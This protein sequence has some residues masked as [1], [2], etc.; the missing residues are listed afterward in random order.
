MVFM[1]KEI[2]EISITGWQE[3]Y[4]REKRKQLFFN[5][6]EMFTIT[7]NL[8]EKKNSKKGFC[9]K[10]TLHFDFCSPTILFF[11]QGFASKVMTSHDTSYTDDVTYTKQTYFHIIL[12]ILTG[13]TI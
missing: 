12:F 7:H 5:I 3:M 10:K 2:L 13:H 11:L 1:G 6:E 4:R 9:R 8:I